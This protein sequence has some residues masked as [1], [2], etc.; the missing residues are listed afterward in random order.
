MVKILKKKYKVTAPEGG[1]YIWVPVK[2]SNKEFHRL[3]NNGIVVCPGEVF[4]SKKHIRFCFAK[5]IKEIKE[6]EKRL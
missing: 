1:I 5:S 4:G 3:L 2:D 6:L